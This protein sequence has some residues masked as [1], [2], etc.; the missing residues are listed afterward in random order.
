MLTAFPYPGGKTKAIKHLK[1]YLPKS[2]RE[3]R[4]PFVGGGSVALHLME[5]H[6]DAHYWINDKF[7]PVFYLWRTLREQPEEMVRW[8]FRAK[9]ELKTDEGLF[10]FCR[11]TFDESNEFEKACK[12]WVLVRLSWGSLAFSG[13]YSLHRRPLT[14]AVIIHI[15]DIGNILQRVNVRI[16]NLDYSEC[17]N[18]QGDGVFVFLDPPY[19]NRSDLYGIDGNLH[20]EFNENRPAFFRSVKACRHRWLVTMDDTEEV[21]GQF[22]DYH[23][24]PLYVPYGLKN[25]DGEELIIT[26]HEPPTA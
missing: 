8:L 2:F 23:L 19:S 17:L 6:A 14:G 21:R 1:T 3:Y 20:R 4:E 16:T 9:E 26:N 5:R 25:C 15:L 22:A 7:P 24:A 11:S 10:D 12:Y 18:V 13:S